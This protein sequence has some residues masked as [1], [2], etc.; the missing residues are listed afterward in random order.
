MNIAYPIQSIQRV[1]R[2]SDSNAGG[3]D[4]YK[5]KLS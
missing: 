1:V 5:T 4:T 3:V 2:E